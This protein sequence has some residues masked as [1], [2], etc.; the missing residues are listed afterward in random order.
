MHNFCHHHLLLLSFTVVVPQIV[1]LSLQK[2][3][4]VFES[5]QIRMKKSTLCKE[6]SAVCNAL[7]KYILCIYHKLYLY[8]LYVSL[9][10]LLQSTPLYST[11]TKQLQQEHAHDALV[12]EG[13][14][15][16]SFSNA[17]NSS[18]LYSRFVHY[19]FFRCQ[20][21]FSFIGC[22]RASK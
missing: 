1:Q 20:L 18:T 11:W 10:R 2:S 22:K 4:T 3:C 15:N 9:N 8:W 5:P 17:T 19:F 21:F 14:I 7:H 6:K 16:L 12:S 13:V